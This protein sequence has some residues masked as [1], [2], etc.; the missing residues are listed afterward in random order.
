MAEAVLMVTSKGYGK[1]VDVNEFPAK[2]RGGK[3]VT[4]FKV[5]EDSGTVVACEH[6]KTEAGQKVLVTTAN[7]QC[8]MTTVD[9]ISVRSRS[10]GGVKLM[11]VAD[12]DEVSAVLV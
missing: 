8:L 12:G 11:N 2:G 9:D 1:V 6:V 7:G 5:T 4:G 3:G 10:A